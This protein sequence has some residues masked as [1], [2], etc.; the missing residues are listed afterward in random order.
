MHGNLT[1][2]SWF[3]TVFLIFKISHSIGTAKMYHFTTQFCKQVQMG[4]G[5]NL[6]RTFPRFETSTT[7]PKERNVSSVYVDWQLQ[8]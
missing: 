2:C 6:Y 3:R 1:E 8:K 7:T 4:A 5:I